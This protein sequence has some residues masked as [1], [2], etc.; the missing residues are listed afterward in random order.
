MLA[1][2]R[3]RQEHSSCYSLFLKVARSGQG[4]WNV[5]LPLADI[6]D[7]PQFSGG[8][9]NAVPEGN[10][11]YMIWRKMHLFRSC[12]YQIQLEKQVGSAPRIQGIRWVS[13]YLCSGGA[14][15]SFCGWVGGM[16][17]S[18]CG[19]VGRQFQLH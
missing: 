19:W 13:R 4:R 9:T 18:C 5:G 2:S 3:V 8:L 12:S 11:P 10:L 6:S 15:L 16:D 7:L 17:G 1:D 14:G